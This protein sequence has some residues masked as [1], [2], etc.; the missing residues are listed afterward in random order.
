MSLWKV[1]SP[2]WA[3]SPAGATSVAASAAPLN[4]DFAEKMRMFTTPQSLINLDVAG[5]EFVNHK[6]ANGNIFGLGFERL[7]ANSGADNLT[8]GPDY[9]RKFR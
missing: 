2:D 1:I 5:A 3:I 9:P 6:P 8:Q 7:G 4:R